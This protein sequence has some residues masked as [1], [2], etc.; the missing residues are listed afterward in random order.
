MAHRR[1]AEFGADPAG[2]VA[3]CVQINA[4]R[5]AKTIEHV[6]EI[7]GGDIAGCTLGIRAAAEAGQ[8]RPFKDM[9]DAWLADSKGDPYCIE[10]AV[11]LHEED[12]GILWKHTDLFTGEVDVRRARRLVVSS[13]STIG[14]ASSLA[15]AC[16]IVDLPAPVAPTPSFAARLS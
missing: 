15:I 4:A 3:E 8:N 13:I 12:F 7:F 16:A 10:S 11:C 5:H 6:N 1:A 9:F 2:G 14:A